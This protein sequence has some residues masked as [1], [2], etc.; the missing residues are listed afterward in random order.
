LG[1]GTGPWAYFYT[2]AAIIFAVLG[3]F[4]IQTGIR[5]KQKR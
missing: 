5:Y 4:A 2:G 3:F 1:V